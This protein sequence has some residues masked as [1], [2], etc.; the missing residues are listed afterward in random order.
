MTANDFRKLA[1]SLPEA[2]EDEHM[3]HPDF[4]VKGKIFATLNSPEEGWA[5]VKLKPEQQAM[6]VRSAPEMFRPVNGGWGVRGAT[7]VCLP[8]A[9]KTTAL[10]ALKDAWRNT[11]PK[12]LADADDVE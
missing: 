2:F 10:H 8:N 7:N 1:L 4:R 6:Y 9:D 3:G 5:M 12:K 11:A